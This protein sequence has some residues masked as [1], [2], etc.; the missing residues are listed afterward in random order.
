[1]SMGE[2]DRQLRAGEGPWMELLG[3]FGMTFFFWSATILI[4]SGRVP[5]RLG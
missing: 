2:I 4:P 3:L 1:M 5:R